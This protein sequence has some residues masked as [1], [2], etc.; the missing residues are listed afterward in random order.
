MTRSR[1]D[2]TGAPSGPR[3]SPPRRLDLRVSDADRRAV[4]DLLAEHYAEGRLD[5]GEHQD[6]VGRAMAA[7]T[8]ADLTPLLADLPPLDGADVRGAR[9]RRLWPVV[10]LALLVMASLA[11]VGALVRLH[12]GLLVVVLVVVA[13]ARLGRRRREVSRRL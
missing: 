1:G 6:R 7:K 3:W 13:L 12:L 8:G 4:A 5:P 10:V 2:D 9:R 11:S